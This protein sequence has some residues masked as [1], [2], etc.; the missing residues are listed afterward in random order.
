MGIVATAQP[1][2]Y[3][4]RMVLVS[5][6]SNLGDSAAL[7]RAAVQALRSR[8]FADFRAS[9]LYRTAP[10]DCP[11]GSPDFVNAAVAFVARGE[12]SPEHLLMF[13]QALEREHGRRASAQRNA[14]RSLDLDLI[15]Y[16]DQTRNTASL[17]LPHPRATL[18]RFVLQPAAAIAPELIWPG[19]QS[20]IGQLCA[21][22]DAT[23]VDPAT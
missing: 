11:P 1:G 10:V 16:N 8:A 7:V 18:R 19:T 17:T 4:A 6:G 2:A 13:L 22:L 20:T 9:A 23:G 12:D 15:L 3:T 21:A 5:L 14:P